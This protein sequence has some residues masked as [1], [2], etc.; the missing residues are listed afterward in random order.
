M[1]RARMQ[2]SAGQ[3]GML[4]PMISQAW[5]MQARSEGV[6]ES[7]SKA[8]ETWRHAYL[9]ARLGVWSLKQIPRGGPTFAKVMGALQETARNGIDW[10]M[11]AGEDNP[12]TLLHH[13]REC[14]RT[15]GID[16]SY[17]CG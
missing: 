1:S 3:Q 10:I 9:G 2:L 8:K 12:S 17:A 6:R 4:W 7:D 15:H 16:E 11:K 5:V 14:L 13:L